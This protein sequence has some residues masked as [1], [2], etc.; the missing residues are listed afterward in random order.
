MTIRAVI[1]DLGGVVLGSPL[2]A[3]RDYE[4]EQGLRPGFLGR[5]IAAERRATAPG[6]AS[7]AASSTMAAFFAGLR[8]RGHRSR[9]AHLGRSR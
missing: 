5:M 7:S 9:R 8:R 3:F 4:R 1:F 2:H 6:R